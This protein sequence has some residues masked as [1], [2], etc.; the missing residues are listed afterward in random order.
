M[1][2]FLKGVAKEV[3]FMTE[4]GSTEKPKPEKEE[5]GFFPRLLVLKDSRR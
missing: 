1:F 4:K 3:K 5:F 2:C